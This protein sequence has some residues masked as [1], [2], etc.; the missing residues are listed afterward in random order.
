M[1]KCFSFVFL[2]MDS[3]EVYFIS[4]FDWIQEQAAVPLTVVNLIAHP[5]IGSPI[6]PV[7]VPHPLLL[8]LRLHC[9]IDSSHITLRLGLCFL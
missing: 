2:Q 7:S 9:Q 1:N 5:S 8:I 6:F 3:S 4:F